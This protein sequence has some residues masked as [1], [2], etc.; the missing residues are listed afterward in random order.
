MFLPSQ[1]AILPGQLFKQLHQDWQEA[2][3]DL[4][5]HIDSIEMSVDKGSIAPEFSNIFR[6]L[7]TPLSSIKV[8]IFGQDPYPTAGV[9]QGLAFSAPSDID[10]IPASLK[11]IFIELQNDLGKPLR[12]NPDLSDWAEQGVLLLNRI[13]TTESG[14][15]LSHTNLQWEK[16]TDQVAEVLGNCKVVA[17]CWGNYAQE[18]SH[19]FKRDWLV[20][21]AHP[22]PLSAYRGFFGSKPFSKVNEILEENAISTVVW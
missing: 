11:N 7:K 6:A 19:F 16:V 22:S 5:G 13:L 18:V 15:S 17:V 3:L 2:L 4:E 1:V 21:S 12:N 20:T 10:R 8:V 9:A 14:N